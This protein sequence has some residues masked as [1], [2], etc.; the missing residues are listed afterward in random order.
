MEFYQVFYINWIGH[1]PPLNGW[2][3]KVHCF[4]GYLGRSF[5]YEDTDRLKLKGWIKLSKANGK[6]NWDNYVY[7][8]QNQH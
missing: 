3:G 1:F 5:R 6:K 7:I 4:L 2:S 8:R